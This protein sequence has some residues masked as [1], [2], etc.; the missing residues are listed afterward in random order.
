MYKVNK[1]M[2][3]FSLIGLGYFVINYFT[4]QSEISKAEINGFVSAIVYDDKGYPIV[5]INNK[6]FHFSFGK[7]ENNPIQINDSISKE[8]NSGMVYQFREG[9]QINVFEW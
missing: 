9:E 1:I 5:T 4:M 8:K 2:I 3:I 6:F 7:K